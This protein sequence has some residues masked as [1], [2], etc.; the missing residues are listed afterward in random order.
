MTMQGADQ[1][2]T[3]RVDVDAITTVLHEAEALGMPS[4]AGAT[5][6]RGMLNPPRDHSGAVKG[7]GHQ[8]HAR[9]ADGSW[10]IDLVEPMAAADAD[11]AEVSALVPLNSASIT[12][13]N[14]DMLH[15]NINAWG[16]DETELAL[17]RRCQI[18]LPVAAAQLG[19][20]MGN[21]DIFYRRWPDPYPRSVHARDASERI[22]FDCRTWFL[23]HFRLEQ[24]NPRW[25]AAAAAIVPDGWREQARRDAQGLKDASTAVAAPDASPA[26]LLR[27]FTVQRQHQDE[28]Q[29]PELSDD[30]LVSLSGDLRPARDLATIGDRSLELLFFRWKIDPAWCAGR[31]ANAPWNDAER[32]QVAIG[33]QEWWKRTSGTAFTERLLIAAETM[34]YEGID[35][36]SGRHDSDADLS[37]RL[38]PVLAKR[39]E[40]PPLDA[41][42]AT[43][44]RLLR[45]FGHY[46]GI[47]AVVDRWPRTGSLASLLAEWDD[48]NGRHAAVDALVTA[49]T[50][51]PSLRMPDV[52]E[53]TQ[54]RFATSWDTFDDPERRIATTATRS[55]VLWWVEHPTPE[56]WQ[57][58]LVWLDGD[59]N[60]PV[61]ARLIASSGEA[62]NDSRDVTSPLAL[63][64]AW[65]ALHDHRLLTPDLLAVALAAETRNR[66]VLAN[67]GMDRRSR[68]P[69]PQLPLTS[70]ARVCDL[71]AV[72]LDLRECLLDDPATA[73]FRMSMTPA[74]RD[75]GVASKC[76]R[77]AN[78]VRQEVTRF[79]LTLPDELGRQLMA[80]AP[81][82]L[83]AP[84]PA[85]PPTLT[86]EE[87][88]A[89]MAALAEAHALGFPALTGASV[90]KEPL[91]LRTGGEL[92]G[93]NIRLADGSW[94]VDE[95]IPMPQ[96]AIVGDAPACTPSHGGR[97]ARFR[98]LQRLPPE[99][100]TRLSRT[101]NLGELIDY[102]QELGLVA[103]AWW[104]SGLDPEGEAIVATVLRNATTDQDHGTHLGSGSGRGK[105]N[106]SLAGIVTVPDIGS[107]LRRILSAWFRARLAS[108][109]ND[110]EADRWSHAASA[111]TAPGDR[112]LLQPLIDRLRRRADLPSAI[113][114]NAPLADRL[115]SWKG[116][117]I[118]HATGAYVQAP[119]VPAQRSDTDALVALLDDDRASRWVD[120]NWT[121]RTV[122]DNALRALNEL[123]NVDWRWL[124]I[125]DPAVKDLLPRPGSDEGAY[126][127]GDFW[128]WAR[129]SWSDAMRHA[130]AHSLA[131]WWRS[132]RDDGPLSPIVG[133]F[134]TMPVYDWGE[135][136]A[137]LRPGDRANDVADAIAARIAVMREDVERSTY[138]GVLIP[139]LVKSA[140]LFPAHAGMTTAFAAWPH[141]PQIANLAM[142]RAGLAGDLERFDTWMMATLT[143]HRDLSFRTLEAYGWEMSSPWFNIGLLAYRPTAHRLEALRGVMAQDL[144]IPGA[145]WLLGY[146]GG[147]VFPVLRDGRWS[148]D[149]RNRLGARAI[150][151]A[152]A[153][154]GL[155]DTRPVTADQLKEWGGNDRV[156]QEERPDFTSCVQ[157]RVCDTVAA[158]LMLC[159]DQSFIAWIPAALRDSK[160]FLAKPVAARDQDI[161]Q[162]R[163]LIEPVVR[164][165]LGDSGLIKKAAGPSD[166]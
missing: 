33:L 85:L 37:V 41:R 51:N 84:V 119:A 55:P 62:W 77:I 164:T 123:W 97:D 7:R 21:F 146:V 16:I 160:S 73:P 68:F 161:A 65:V 133:S 79:K 166:F 134:R 88:V 74:E 75:A 50:G 116:H 24:W 18:G 44:L 94:L 59:L 25:A 140:C 115:M 34:P 54:P 52:E 76:E 129:G 144:D 43:L 40:K 145:R 78:E 155:M 95:C 35:N 132:H 152:L 136:V 22:R 99:A 113:D 96:D 107:G 67:H 91:T 121:P 109:A 102:T 122:G 138:Q 111:I 57:R 90:T 148:D 6:V 118:D 143:S 125:E 139:S 156:A 154:T 1:A 70:D 98:R 81:A 45:R 23:T 135:I 46:D 83:P 103:V 31:D 127:C 137:E 53:L 153:Q 38:A 108:A 147:D 14:A 39:W 93:V 36:L 63:P 150:P 71:A 157:V 2:D 29:L 117:E 86:A 64:L 149:M 69:A 26:G 61:T 92:Y 4:L 27:A 112:P 58:L 151:A 142:V 131:T 120:S 13:P 114:S 47:D 32:S 15:L 12:D 60:N 48:V 56:R 19:H 89:C 158:R 162:L 163:T 105:S 124:T 110:D 159:D 106:I 104:E 3:Y 141:T 72:K 10:L 8:I 9:L 17:A 11:P 126:A 87:R 5:L 128:I 101:S 66:A 130:V 82:S 80:G 30:V 28:P 49:W 20:N 165:M 42:P 100:Q